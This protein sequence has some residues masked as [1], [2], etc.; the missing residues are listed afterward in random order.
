[1]NPTPHKDAPK[2]ADVVNRPAVHFSEPEHVVTEPKLTRDEKLVAL[3]SWEKV[4]EQLDVA[5]DEGMPPAPDAPSENP[6]HD[7]IEAAAETLRGPADTAPPLDPE[8]IDKNR[9][10]QR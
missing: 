9:R 8:A 1:M 5:S 2:V 6:L 10:V 7:R 4:A 3:A